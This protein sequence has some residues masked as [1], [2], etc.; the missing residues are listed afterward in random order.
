MVSDDKY[1]V[2][3]M[4]RTRRRQL[5]AAVVRA[6]GEAVQGRVR[7]LLVA[8]PARAVLAYLAAENEIP[9]DGIIAECL[10]AQRAVYLPRTGPTPQFVCWRPGERLRQGPGDVFEPH[11]GPSFPDKGCAVALVPLVGWAD[12]GARLGRGAGFYDRVF[13]SGSAAIVRVGLAYEFQQC[14]HLPRDPWDVRLD[15]VITE[16]RVVRCGAG[17]V[18]RSGSLQKGGLR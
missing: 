13:A 6:A 10:R 1:A 12:D 17:E 11:D 7:R 9:T 8:H 14:A 16:R 18:L 3:R 4:L 2:R 15:Y 5:S